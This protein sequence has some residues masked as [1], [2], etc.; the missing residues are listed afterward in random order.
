MWTASLAMA[1]RAKKKASPVT[2]PQKVKKRAT[3]QAN[4]LTKLPVA[5]T[6]RASP[7]KAAVGDEPVF[8]YFASDG[9]GR[10]RYALVD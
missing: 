3:A 6:G 1:D 8:A 7:A 2:K 5:M 10:F 9:C 4:V